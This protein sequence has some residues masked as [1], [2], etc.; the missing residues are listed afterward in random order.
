MG[1]YNR[2][3]PG[4]LAMTTLE[5]ALERSQREDDATIARWLLD[6][7]GHDTQGG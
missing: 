4:G 1:K 2:G 5:T 7:F 6:L 3:R